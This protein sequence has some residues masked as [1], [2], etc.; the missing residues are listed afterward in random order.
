MFKYF[1]VKVYCLIILAEFRQATLSSLKVG[2]SNSSSAFY[3]PS[4]N[5]KISHF[6]NPTSDDMGSRLRSRSKSPINDR[7]L[8]NN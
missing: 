6:G 3:K 5:S 2:S 4:N 1:L 7:N 8:V